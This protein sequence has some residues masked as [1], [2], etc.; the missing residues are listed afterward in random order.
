MWS[1][2]S[3]WWTNQVVLS[4]SYNTFSVKLLRVS[5]SIA[6]EQGNAVQGERKREF[7]ISD[8]VTLEDVRFIC[9]T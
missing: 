6:A 4:Y 1:R 2:S 8:T 7:S 5:N 3:L 9:Q